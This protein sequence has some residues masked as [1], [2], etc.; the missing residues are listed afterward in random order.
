MM[1]IATP[2]REIPKAVTTIPIA[3]A[4]IKDVCTALDRSASLFAPKN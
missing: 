2:E 1:V 4:R 3:S